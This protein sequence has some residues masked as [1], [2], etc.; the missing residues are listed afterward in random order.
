MKFFRKYHKWL[1]VGLTFFII[2]FSVSGIVLN[3]RKIFSGSDVN[4]NTLPSEYRYKNWNNASVKGTLKLNN[5]SILVYGNVGIWLTDSSF[6]SY[7]D[8][9]NGFAKGV[10]NKKIYKL[11]LSKNGELL[12]ATL[13]GLY[14]YNYDKK[15]WFKNNFTSDVIMDIAEKADT[16]LLLTRS[17]LYKTANFIEFQEITL[18]HPL[19]YDNKVGLFKTLWI[20]H[21]GEIYGKIGVI[22]TDSIGL[23]FIFLRVTGLIYFFAPGIIRRRKKKE[24]GAKKVV[25]INRF[26]LKWH[27]KLGWILFIFLVISTTTGMFLRPPLLIPI[28]NKNVGKI[29][30]SKLDTDNAWYDK[31]RRVIFDESNDR[32]VFAT[33]DGVYTI[34]SNFKNYMEPAA[35]Q[36]PISVMGVNVFEQ[37]DKRMFL[38][39]SFEGLFVWDEL[40]GRVFDYVEQK[41]YQLVVRSGAPVGRHMV[42]GYSRDFGGGQLIFDYILGTQNLERNIRF[43]EM[44]KIIENQQIS[45]WNVALEF[46]TMRIWSALIGDFYIL[47]IP[48]SGLAMLFILISGFIVWFKIHR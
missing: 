18:P 29:P 11:H 32:Y 41:E 4:R 9:C 19:E 31:L 34:D 44:P 45:L 15:A 28:A 47:L 26:S 22:F 1:G 24:Q 38:I 30:F 43:P 33:L 42:A 25:Q 35:Y 23:V 21:S 7:S 14:Q 20:I 12:A 16:I 40:S 48:L 2:L 10:D 17:H 3:H 5:D 27:N 46:H 36:P 13:F 8:F 37:I 39:G 6:N